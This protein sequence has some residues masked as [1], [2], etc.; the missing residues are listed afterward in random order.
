MASPTRTST[1]APEV[2]EPLPTF[3]QET[4][5]PRKLLPLVDRKTWGHWHVSP[6]K[7]TTEKELASVFGYLIECHRSGN[8]TGPDLWQEFQSDFEDWPETAF[9]T[10]SSHMLKYVRDFLKIRGVYVPTD[11]LRIGKH[12]FGIA[13]QSSFHYWSAAEIQEVSSKSNSF[14]EMLKT[15]GFRESITVPPVEEDIP[16]PP[17]ARQQQFP[18]QQRQL[19]SGTPPFSPGQP[20]LTFPADMPTPRQLTNLA[21]M[22]VRQTKVRWWQI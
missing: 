22:Y 19:Q 6:E 13:N 3:E 2:D 10:T 18:S 4:P 7:A 12:I 5:I 16:A 11:G 9:L 15:P 1:P 8:L 20:S 14:R 17:T 21:Q